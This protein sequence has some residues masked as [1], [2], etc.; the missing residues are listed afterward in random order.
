MLLDRDA[1]MVVP[2]LLEDRDRLRGVLGHEVRILP[3][4]REGVARE[5][6]VLHAEGGDLVR[7]FDVFARIEHG[8]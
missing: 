4:A 6:L 1:M 8:F 7:R 2:L 3:G 5:R